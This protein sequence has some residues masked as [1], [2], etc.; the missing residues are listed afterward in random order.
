LINIIIIQKTSDL[1]TNLADKAYKL[2]HFLK[3]IFF[4]NTKKPLKKKWFL[5]NGEL[6]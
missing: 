3:D 1:K 2:D 5:K 4:N 6:L